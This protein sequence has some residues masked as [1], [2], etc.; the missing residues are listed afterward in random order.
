[1]NQG[2]TLLIQVS[3]CISERCDYTQVIRRK[4]LSVKERMMMMNRNGL[5]AAI[6]K[7]HTGNLDNSSFRR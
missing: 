4:N 7:L 3:N 1:M 2:G 6:K 5:G